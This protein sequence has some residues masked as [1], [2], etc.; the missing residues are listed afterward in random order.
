MTT[1][2]QQLADRLAEIDRLIDEADGQGQLTAADAPHNAH[3][4]AAVAAAR[5]ARAEVNAQV[6]AADGGFTE[7]VVLELMGHRRLAGRLTEQNIAGDGFLRLDL[8]PGDVVVPALTQLYRPGA[9]YC[10]TPTTED[11]ARRVAARSAPA[12]V[13]RW[14]LEAPATPPPFVPGFNPAAPVEYDDDGGDG[15]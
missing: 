8:Y 2:T 12:P 4:L 15:G 1:P 9:V 11:I 6:T 5:L 13:Q 10:I 3:A 14:E 7:W